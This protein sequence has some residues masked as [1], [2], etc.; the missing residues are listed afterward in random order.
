MRKQKIIAICMVVFVAWILSTAPTLASVNTHIAKGRPCEL[1]PGQWEPGEGGDAPFFLPYQQAWIDDDA[2]VAEAEKSRRIGLTFA[3]A[4]RSVERRITLGTDH[5]FASRDFESAKLFIEDCAK[6]ARVFGTVA[7]DL[8]E[9]VID[10][11]KGITAHVLRFANGAKIMALSSNPEVFRSKGGDITLDEFAFH[12]EQKKV[13]KAAQ[14]SAKIWGHQVRIISTHNGEGSLF[15]KL[16]E[17]IK[18]GQRKWSLHTI[19]LRDAVDQGLYEV[20]R[21][22]AAK[23]ADERNRIIGSPDMDARQRFLDEIK[24]DCV[25][26]SEWDEE[27]CCIPNTDEGAY[28]NYEQIDQCVDREAMRSLAEAIE[29]LPSGPGVELY[30]GY[31]VGR[32]HDLAVLWVVQKIGDVYHTVMLRTMRNLRYRP[33][34][35]LL[36]ALV[37]RPELKRLCID[38]TGI[39]NMLAEYLEEHQPTKVE[40]VTFTSPWKS[41][42]APYFRRWFQDRL[43]RIPE[44]DA[45]REDL[46]KT[47][48]VTTDAGNIRLLAGRDDAGH[49][50]RFWAGVLMC[51]AARDP[52]A[53]PVPAPQERKPAGW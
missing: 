12:G 34:E 2:Q 31:D 39:G 14:A 17:Q 44:N 36:K 11:E 51:E 35:V 38:E 19:T 25:D 9:Q 3:E 53:K 20:I 40:K 26:S 18:A 1:Q 28:L 30:A 52:N 10:K 27:Y 8:G 15:N 7:E 13:L 45:L 4:Y 48:K 6:F 33:Q 16:I 23:T 5:Y 29:D 49:A 46:H 47:R 37:D 42:A 24:D 43:I 50:D 32:K 41:T 21:S 22:M